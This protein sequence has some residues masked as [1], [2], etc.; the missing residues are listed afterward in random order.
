MAAP[1]R[2]LP[3]T[4]TVGRE[5]DR[6]ARREA[7]IAGLEAQLAA[8][9]KTLSDHHAR[10][11]RAGP[12]GATGSTVRIDGLEARHAALRARVTRYDAQGAQTWGSFMAEIADAWQ[13]LELAIADL[14]PVE[15]GG[16]AATPGSVPPGVFPGPVPSK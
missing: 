4:C 2:E 11:L 5:R 15:P 10:L 14:P 13:T 8:W 1:S 7:R 16:R 3:A 9:G 6:A 12:A